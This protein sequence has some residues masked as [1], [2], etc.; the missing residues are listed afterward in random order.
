MPGLFIVLEGGEGAGK[1]TQARLLVEWLAA[2]RIPHLRTREPG[3]TPL[4]EQVRSLLLESDSVTARSELL[5]MLAARAAL[6]ETVVEPAL[7]A[8]QV[9]VADRFDLSTLAYQGGGRGLPMAEVRRINDFAT[10]GRK[11]DITI[12]LRL[13]PAVGEARRLRDG[14]SADRIERAG[15]DFH[16]RVEAAYA[17][18]AGSESGITV[19][20]ADDEVERVHGRILDVLRLRFPETFGGAEG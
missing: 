20:S 19:L 18:L 16:R 6:V 11:A 7:A 5:L 3:G 13:D 15:A 10:G 2:R 1:S 8:G 4:G 12:L 14:R 9:V 17:L